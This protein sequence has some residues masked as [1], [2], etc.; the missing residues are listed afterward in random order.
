[1]GK[2]NGGWLK[3]S[4]DQINGL[5]DKGCSF[6]GKISFDGTVQINGEFKGEISSEGTL[7]VGQDARVAGTIKVDTLI[8]YGTLNGKVEAKNRIEIHVPSIVTADLTTKT[9]SI[10]EGALF[11]GRCDMHQTGKAEG[12]PIDDPA[13][14]KAAN[15]DGAA[16]EE[17][18]AL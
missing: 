12:L 4:K 6:E 8:C 14:L 15:G 1:M 10:D 18:A 2:N 13:S 7:V 5:L 9:L 11:Q 17:A 16:R 3:T